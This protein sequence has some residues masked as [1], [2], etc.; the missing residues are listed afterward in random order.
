MIV[1]NTR[2]KGQG[3]KNLRFFPLKTLKN[4][5]FN[6]KFHPKMTTKLRHCFPSF[7]NVHGQ[8]LPPVP[9]LS[10]SSYTPVWNG[11]QKELKQTKVS[12]FKYLFMYLL[13]YLQCWFDSQVF[14][15]CLKLN[16]T[17]IVLYVFLPTL[18]WFY[19]IQNVYFPL[20]HYLLLLA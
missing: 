12:F 17:R 4:F 9:L 19:L 7:D 16:I 20:I 18:N 5:I 14:D 13:S 11:W 3:R 2:K 15:G 8:T 6:E 10:S 1:C